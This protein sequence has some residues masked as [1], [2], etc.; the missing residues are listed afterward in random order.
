MDFVYLSMYLGL[1]LLQNV[2][3]VRLEFPVEPT[4]IICCPCV[5][6]CPADTVL[7]PSC[8]CAYNVYNP[9]ACAI[10]I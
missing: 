5:T 9:F 1:F 8:P 10:K 3:V 2:S 7:E 4:L 6:V